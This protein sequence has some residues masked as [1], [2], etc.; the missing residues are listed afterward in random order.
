MIDI[1]IV[2]NKD[3]FVYGFEAC[4]HSG[5]AEH[6][7]DIVCAAISALAY[8]AVGAVSEMTKVEA[9]WSYKDG[10]MLYMV[11]SDIAENDRSIVKTILDAIVIGFK[12]IELSY[13]GY[14]SIRI[15]EV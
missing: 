14:V 2:K 15:K 11:H 7:K 8:T 4:G 3:G 12:Q 5:Y 6:G 10:Y 13:K 1:S 9:D